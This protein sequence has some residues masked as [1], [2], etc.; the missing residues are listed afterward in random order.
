[1]TETIIERPIFL[2]SKYNL[3]KVISDDRTGGLSAQDTANNNGLRLK[4]KN[5]HH[6]DGRISM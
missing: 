3:D 1:M 2:L 6:G 4:F 5:F